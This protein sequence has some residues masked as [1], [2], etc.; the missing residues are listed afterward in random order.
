[1]NQGMGAQIKMKKNNVNNGNKTD[2]DV[3]QETNQ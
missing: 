1:M 2:Q 3:L